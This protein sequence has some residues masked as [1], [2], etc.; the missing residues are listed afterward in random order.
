L[1]STADPETETSRQKILE[2][3]KKRDVLRSKL[4][5]S[6]RKPSLFLGIGLLSCGFMTLVCSTVLQLTSIILIGVGLFT[7]GTILLIANPRGF[8]RAEVIDY[9]TMPS[10]IS[11]SRLLNSFK[12]QKGVYLPPNYP[13]QIKTESIYLFIPLSGEDNVPYSL[14]VP[15]EKTI[16]QKPNGILLVP[17]GYGVMALFERSMGIDFS[18][19]NLSLLPD[20]LYKALVEET[21]IASEFTMRLEDFIFTAKITGE[22]CHDYCNKIRKETIICGEIGCYVCS[23]IACTIAKSTKRPVSIEKIEV[24]DLSVQIQFRALET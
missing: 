9:T 14:E 17:F 6:I 22:F 24:F 8:L 11:I 18:K 12:A 13:K 20:I 10:I 1:K 23:A 3:K 16:V 21:A 4:L 2:L 5:A 19:C 7:M 15:E